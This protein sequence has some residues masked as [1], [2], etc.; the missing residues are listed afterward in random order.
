MNITD[1]GLQYLKN[2]EILDLHENTNISDK[3]FLFLTKI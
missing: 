3:G 1:E 2:V